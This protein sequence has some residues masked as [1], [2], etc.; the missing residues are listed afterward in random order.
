MVEGNGW[1]QEAVVEA[2]SEQE[3]GKAAKP[4]ACPQCSLL[5]STALPLKVPETFKMMPPATSIQCMSESMEDISHSNHNPEELKLLQNLWDRETQ[6]GVWHKHIR[7][8][9]KLHGKEACTG[10]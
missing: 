2:E 9:H 10:L 1:E 5:S 6:I 8:H 3:V 4:Q 7:D